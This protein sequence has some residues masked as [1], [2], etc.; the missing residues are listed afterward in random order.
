MP[1]SV[2]SCLVWEGSRGLH[3]RPSSLCSSFWSG[4]RVGFLSVSQA[5][6]VLSL[7]WKPSVTPCSQENVQMELA[8]PVILCPSNMFPLSLL[9]FPLRTPQYPAI[10]GSP[11]LPLSPGTSSFYLECLFPPIFLRLVSSSSR[12]SSLK[13]SSL[14]PPDWFATL[15]GSH[16]AVASVILFQEELTT[17]APVLSCPLPSIRGTV[18]KGS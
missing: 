16:C 14:L 9:A 15:L 6:P 13:A 1:S 7:C 3:F 4:F 18:T 11:S 10:G 2:Q 8:E 5:S 12:K 17:Q